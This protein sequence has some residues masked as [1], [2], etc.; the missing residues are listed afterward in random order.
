MVLKVGTERSV[1]HDTID[2]LG[3]KNPECAPLKL[4]TVPGGRAIITSAIDYRKPPESQEYR[5]KLYPETQE[6]RPKLYPETR[7]GSKKQVTKI[8]MNNINFKFKDV[9]SDK[10]AFDQ[11]YGV[12]TGIFCYNDSGIELVRKVLAGESRWTETLEGAVTIFHAKA[13]QTLNLELNTF[14]KFIDPGSDVRKVLTAIGARIAGCASVD[15]LMQEVDR[16]LV[17]NMGF[18]TL[19]HL[20]HQYNAKWSAEKKVASI[21]G[22]GPGLHGKNGIIFVHSCKSVSAGS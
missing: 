6:Y 18:D 2:F 21:E 7:I 8:T 11:I 17:S 3:T 10:G 9:N 20:Y 15:Q 14:F 22:E 5:P 1:D 13:G 16:K 19:R 12:R 4:A